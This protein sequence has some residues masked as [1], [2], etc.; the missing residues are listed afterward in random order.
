M[1]DS[2]GCH[3]SAQASTWGS[4]SVPLCV[5]DCSGEDDDRI[6]GQCVG[7]IYEMHILLDERNEEVVLEESGNSLVPNE[8]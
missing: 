3:R 2:L 4:Q 5:V 8:A 6:L 1:M 7:E